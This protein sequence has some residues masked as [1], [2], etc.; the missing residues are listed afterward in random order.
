MTEPYYASMDGLPSR[1]NNREAWVYIDGSGWREIN[2]ATHDM[3]SQP[4]NKD[5]FD[6]CFPNTP[7]LPP[8]AFKGS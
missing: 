5:M 2:A 7:P 8:E 4:M 1:S 6:Q 3:N